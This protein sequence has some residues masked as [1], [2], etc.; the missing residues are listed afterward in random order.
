MDGHGTIPEKMTTWVRTTLGWETDPFDYGWKN[1]YD[2]D[3]PGPL[4]P[5]DIL[6]LVPT[7]VYISYQ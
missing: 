5:A 2:E 3:I 7:P 6:Q 4:G 1:F